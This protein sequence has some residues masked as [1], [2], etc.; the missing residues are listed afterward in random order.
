VQVAL[1]RQINVRGN[2][3]EI[4]L[5]LQEVRHASIEWVLKFLTLSVTSNR[6]WQFSIS[7]VCLGISDLN[8]LLDNDGC[9]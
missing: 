7:I 3:T 2:I 1:L 9:A 8:L 5:K 6:F 4:P